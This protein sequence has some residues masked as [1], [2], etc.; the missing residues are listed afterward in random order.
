MTLY[1]LQ[2]LI[3]RNPVAFYLD[4]K[5]RN[6]Y[7][8]ILTEIQ[9]RPEAE[10]YKDLVGKSYEFVVNAE[11]GKIIEQKCVQNLQSGLKLKE[12]AAKKI[13][14]FICSDNRKLLE[15]LAMTY[16]SYIHSERGQ[17]HAIRAF[18]EYELLGDGIFKPEE[19]MKPPIIKNEVPP[20]NPS[21]RL[22]FEKLGL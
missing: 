4:R 6:R 22:A 11:K 15:M 16:N 18:A 9:G 2:C 10:K 17:M 20:Q 19:P 13:F 8:E 14:Q 12:N 3:E 7:N 21:I 1:P 5:I